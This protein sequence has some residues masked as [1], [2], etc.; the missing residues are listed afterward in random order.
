M[1]PR[2][3]MYLLPDWDNSV[4]RGIICRQCS[5]ML[6]L[7]IWL[8]DHYHIAIEFIAVCM[9]EEQLQ[10]L[11]ICHQCSLMLRLSIW[12]IGHYHSSSHSNYAD[13]LLMDYLMIRNFN[14]GLQLRNI[15]STINRS[16]RRYLTRVWSRTSLSLCNELRSRFARL[17][18]RR[19]MIWKYLSKG[20]YQEYN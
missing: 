17:D 6:R 13:R 7:S 11:I 2:C 1:L 15:T 9:Q 12:L 19:H 16:I 18:N 5:L 8:I 3:L 4:S 10:T 20:K 14:V